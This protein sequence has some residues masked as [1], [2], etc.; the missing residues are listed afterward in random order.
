MLV[1]VVAG[2]FKN[3]NEFTYVCSS[4]R[5][6]FNESEPFIQ[7]ALLLNSVNSI[8]IFNKNTRQIKTKAFSNDEI[9]SENKKRRVIL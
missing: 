3:Y 9:Q 8:R 6:E 4:V 1:I 5:V 2:F 7:F